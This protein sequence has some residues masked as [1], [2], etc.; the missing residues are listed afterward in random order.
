MAPPHRVSETHGRSLGH[1]GST[2]AAGR[3]RDRQTGAGQHG[4]RGRL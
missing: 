4:D 1:R 2:L 3:P